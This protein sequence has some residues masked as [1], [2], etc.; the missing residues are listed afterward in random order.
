L[1]VFKEAIHQSPDQAGNFH[2]VDRIYPL[3]TYQLDLLCSDCRY[4]LVL[5]GNPLV[6]L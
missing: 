2:P 3:G 1:Q 6:L 4:T 5:T